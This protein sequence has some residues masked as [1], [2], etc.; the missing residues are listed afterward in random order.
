MIE[1]SAKDYLRRVQSR[2]LSTRASIY[3]YYIEASR[4]SSMNYDP[5]TDTSS[6]EASEI[7][8]S[9]GAYNFNSDRLTQNFIKSQKKHLINL[10]KL[11]IYYAEVLSVITNIDYGTAYKIFMSMIAPSKASPQSIL[12]VVKSIDDLISKLYFITDGDRMEKNRND[13]DIKGKSYTHSTRTNK[14]VSFEHWFANDE[15]DASVEKNFGYDYLSNIVGEQAATPGVRFVNGNRYDERAGKEVAK[16]FNSTNS[17]G[18][19][20]TWS[21]L[22]PAFCYFGS[23]E[24]DKVFDFYTSGEYN[25][26]S[27]LSA[28]IL[29][30]NSGNILSELVLDDEKT[31]NTMT[32]FY[33]D[34]NL[35]ITSEDGHD[36][37]KPIEPVGVSYQEPDVNPNDLFFSLMDSFSKNGSISNI[38][39]ENPFS[40]ESKIFKVGN[41]D[42]NL[43]EL[44]IKVWNK[45]TISLIKGKNSTFS[46]LLS[47]PPIQIKSLMVGQENWGAEDPTK[48]LSMAPYYHF[49]YSMIAQIEVVADFSGASIKGLTWEPLTKALLT[50]KKNTTGSNVLLCRIRPFEFPIMGIRQAK[51]LKLPVYDNYFILEVRE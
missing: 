49:R 25:E 11:I 36:L 23:S 2:L 30:Y 35:T 14:I 34:L 41:Q 50:T 38:S 17:G 10:R 16:Y 13:L 22:T 37:I 15:F 40:G 48:N 8:S 3:A 4:A 26:Y 21:Y 33:S 20:T 9:S 51:G 31:K 45:E 27:T 29:A 1:D 28:N 39:T 43:D 47:Q 12:A 7:M 19:V 6:K 46:Q 32:N 18:S 24:T 5:H 42:I 44:G